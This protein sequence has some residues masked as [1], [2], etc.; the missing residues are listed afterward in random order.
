M[1][2][3]IT[4]AGTQTRLLLCIPC[5]TVVNMKSPNTESEK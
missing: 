3:S 4:V 2:D 5:V 1:D